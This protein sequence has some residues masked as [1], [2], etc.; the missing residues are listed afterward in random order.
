MSSKYGKNAKLLLFF[1]AETTRRQ[2]HINRL[3]DIMHGLTTIYNV[4]LVNEANLYS[5]FIQKPCKKLLVILF[6]EDGLGNREFR[7][8]VRTSLA[9]RM[10]II[11]I[12]DE[13]MSKERALGFFFLNGKRRKMLE[14][15]I[16]NSVCFE[17]DTLFRAT[18]LVDR[19]QA[20]CRPISS[21]LADRSANRLPRIM[22]SESVNLEACLKSKKVVLRPMIRSQQQ[23]RSH[24]IA[25]SLKNSSNNNKNNNSQ[26]QKTQF[27]PLTI[28]K[29]SSQKNTT[30]PSPSSSSSSSSTSS[31]SSSSS[32]SLSP[33]KTNSSKV[34]STSG[35][36]HPPPP[37][38]RYTTRN[39]SKQISCFFPS[40][41]I[42]TS[43]AN[44]TAHNNTYNT[45]TNNNISPPNGTAIMKRQQDN[46]QCSIS[47]TKMIMKTPAKLSC[48]II[49]ISYEVE[50]D[51]INDF[52]D[53][54]TEGHE[55]LHWTITTKEQHFEDNNNSHDDNR[56]SEGFSSLKDQNKDFASRRFSFD[57]ITKT[58]VV[59]DPQRNK[60]LH[61]NFPYGADV[62]KRDS[63]SDI[64]NSAMTSRRNS[65][66]ISNSVSS[67]MDEINLESV[68][69][70][71]NIFDSPIPSP[72]L[73]RRN[74]VYQDPLPAFPDEVC[75]PP[76]E[77]FP[78][79]TF[80]KRRP[81]VFD[82]LLT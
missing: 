68:V 11:G 19:I 53:R 7:E 39:P 69:D 24:R 8:G 48:P 40:A 70:S 17:K 32:S 80:Q 73:R 25:Y 82:V 64:I 71:V 1:I 37:R 58:Y 67:S 36:S 31:S 35:R 45:N 51:E 76:L 72:I 66:M 55:K 10:N 74:V 60:A 56:I 21:R 62:L 2:P 12:L 41:T 38:L 30:K 20:L 22:E 4:R 6:N 77:K 34:A 14:N 29:E 61:V 9:A 26:Q 27:P 15:I 47:P 28:N 23:Q 52:P 81:S 18:P 78:C 42:P 59:F 3:L 57:Y 43:N 44:S 79:E 63:L 46:N 65:M 33:A 54:I 13:G 16:T 5:A 75:F 50:N 49:E